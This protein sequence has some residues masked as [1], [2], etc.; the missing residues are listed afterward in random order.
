MRVHEHSLGDKIRHGIFW[1]MYGLFKYIPPPIGDTLRSFVIRMFSSGFRTWYVREG[2]TL[3]FPE[4]LRVGRGTSFNEWV[5]VVACGGVTIGENVRLAPRV[6]LISVDHTFSDPSRPVHGQGLDAQPIVI[7]DDVWMG[8]GATVLKGVT[9]GR[10]AIVAA[11]A[12]VTR[13]VEPYTIVGGV[14][15]RVIGRRAVGASGAAED[16]PRPTRVAG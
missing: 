13:D 9:V 15:A 4:R 8:M 1:N 11:G 7:E 16:V 12:V 14:P 6:S 2:V 5:Y 3:W 10:G